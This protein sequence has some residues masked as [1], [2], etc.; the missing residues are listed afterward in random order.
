MI[1]HHAILSQMKTIT[2]KCSIP[3][4][5]IHVTRHTHASFLLDAG[6][7]MKEIQVRLRYSKISMTMDTYG[8]LGKE[9]KEK[10]IEKL[11]AHL[12]S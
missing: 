5:G 12:N 6:A 3:F 10:T 8:H 7:S 4:L 1:T 11:V 2:E 9:T